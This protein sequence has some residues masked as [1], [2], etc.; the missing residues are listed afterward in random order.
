[1]AGK[2]ATRRP[3]SRMVFGQARKQPKMFRAGL[4]AHVSTNDQQTIPLQTAPCGTTPRVA[5]GPSLCRSR[6]SAPAPAYVSQST[7]H[8][9]SSKKLEN[10]MAALAVYFMYYNFVRI[11]QTLRVSPAMAAGVTSKLWS[12]TDIVAL[13]EAAE[14]SN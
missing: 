11:H 10:H 9:M 8:R 5:A 14:K 12:V 7:T 3:N 4:Y 13:I 1:M 6:R 2:L